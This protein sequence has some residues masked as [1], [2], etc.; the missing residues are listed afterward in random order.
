MENTI[1]NCGWENNLSKRIR[2][3]R[4]DM[5]L[6]QNALA[7]ELNVSQQTISGWEAG[8]SIPDMPMLITLCNFFGREV[9]S[10]L[11]QINDYKTHDNKWICEKTGLSEQ[12]II[13]LQRD[14]SMVYTINYIQTCSCAN[15]LFKG[16]RDYIEASPIPL[17]KGEEVQEVHIDYQD[18]DSEH[19]AFGIK[20]VYYEGVKISHETI[21]TTI[22]YRIRDNLETIRK[23]MDYSLRMK[24]K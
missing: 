15:S 23:K 5:G 10:L 18:G 11:G 16:I 1:Y 13:N 21:R 24:V 9:D 19:F 8:K 3:C 17:P 14:P 4:N 12:T 22:L 2:E 6:S 20:D 7:K